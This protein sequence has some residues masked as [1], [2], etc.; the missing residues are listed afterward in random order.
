MN[1][2]VEASPRRV[3]LQDMSEQHPA[4]RSRLTRD[5]VLYTLARFGLLAGI[6]LLLVLAGVPAVVALLLA[7]VVSLPL[8]LIVLPGLRARVNV[9]VA[10]T[11][12][13]RRAER[14]R[15]RA[16]L[17]GDQLRGEERDDEG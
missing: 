15:L 12:Q 9:G 17:R 14:D 16:Q 3:A 10:E 2:A 1:P 6:A 11:T 4:G 13:R 5:L 7:L 8:S